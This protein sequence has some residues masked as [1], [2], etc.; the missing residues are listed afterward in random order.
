LY[1]QLIN[2]SKGNGKMQCVEE[3]KIWDVNSLH[4]IFLIKICKQN[5]EDCKRKWGKIDFV[6]LT[7]TRTPYKTLTLALLIIRSNRIWSNVPD[8]FNLKCQYCADYRCWT[9]FIFSRVH[10]LFSVLPTLF[11]SISRNK[12]KLIRCHNFSW[13]MTNNLQHISI[14]LKLIPYENKGK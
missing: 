5:S 2:N 12:E 7:Q 14:I 4:T 6:A 8:T 10:L 3:A 9:V 13:Y 11:L 1:N